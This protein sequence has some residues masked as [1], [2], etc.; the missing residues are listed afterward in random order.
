MTLPPERDASGRFV[1]PEPDEP[2]KPSN[3]G[4]HP[5][6]K[7]LFGWVDSPRTPLLLLIL[8]ILISVGLIVVDLAI[9]RKEYLDFAKAT[10]FYAIWGFSAFAIAVLSGWPLGKLL[11]RDEDYYG[12]AD[13][14]P[15]D[16]ESDS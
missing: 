9:Y 13:T 5:L 16:V 6:S 1:K 12:E 15:Q 2:L 4:M 8:V 3:E 7:F 14:T 11:R 10:G